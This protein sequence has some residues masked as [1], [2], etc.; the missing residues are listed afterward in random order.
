MI[1]KIG[2]YC[3]LFGLLAACKPNVT[4]TKKP[5][6]GL[7]NFS[8]YLAIGNSLTSGFSDNSLTVSGQ[9]NSYPQRLFEQFQLIPGDSGG[10]KSYFVQPL[11]H[12]DN[13]YPNAK[14]VLGYVHDTCTTDSTLSAVTYPN[15]IPDPI[16]AQRY[17]WQNSNYNHGQINNLGVPGI[18][19]ADFSVPGYGRGNPYSVRFFHDTSIGSTPFDELNYRVHNLHPSFFTMWL[20]ANDVLG[21]AVAG[22]IGDGTGNAL[23]NAFGYYNTTDVTPW[24]VFYKNYD[25]AVRVATSTGARGVLINI[26][27]ITTLPYCTVIPSNGLVI[28][29]QDSADALNAYW[30]TTY[31]AVVINKAFQVGNNQYMVKDHNN[32]LR[33]SVPGELILMSIPQEQLTCTAYGSYQPIDG[34]YVLT[35]EEIQ[36]IRTAT[37]MYNSYIYQEALT[38]N[39]TY[40]D[41][42]A[43]LTTL[44]TGIVFNGINYNAG[45]M[46]GGAFSLDG[47]HL[48]QRGYAL[49]ANKILTD[50]NTYYHSTI[51]MADVN[52]YHGV[53]FP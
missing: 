5:I 16:D 37:L 34:Q 26:P 12:S 36:M 19:V 53:L 50:I 39:L 42:N 23:P 48:T 49:V 35:T 28:K 9:L 8:N 13:G 7:A 6:P 25:S 1:K 33:Q 3:L 2:F 44:Y 46:S 21:Y 22:G 41:M 38:Y 52:K 11:L 18:R 40:V 45:Y 4:L 31:P 14:Y 20:G 29:S 17:T 15:F 24:T 32:I 30:K 47:I 51:P 10:A 43:Y 27:D